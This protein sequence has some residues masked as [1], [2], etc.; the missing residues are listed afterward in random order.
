MPNIY[1]ALRWRS[2]GTVVPIV[3][4]GLSNAGLKIMVIVLS[5]FVP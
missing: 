1:G 5:A 3:A 2:G 4:H